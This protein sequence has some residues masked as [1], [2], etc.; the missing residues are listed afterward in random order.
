MR[1]DVRDFWL[2]RTSMMWLCRITSQSITWQDSTLSDEPGWVFDDIAVLGRNPSPTDDWLDGLGT[3]LL[4]RG[5]LRVTTTEA[6]TYTNLCQ[7][8]VATVSPNCLC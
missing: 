6:T 1:V 7:V 5:R 3:W 8:A 2:G 4:R